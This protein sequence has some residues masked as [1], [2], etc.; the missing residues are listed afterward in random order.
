MKR[1]VA[2][3]GAI[4]SVLVLVIGMMTLNKQPADLDVDGQDDMLL[5]QLF[6]AESATLGADYYIYSYRELDEI[7]EA[8]TGI[9]QGERENVNALDGAYQASGET[10]KAGSGL[11]VTLK[12]GFGWL[13]T[14]MGLITI[15]A[16]VNAFSATIIFKKKQA[17]R[18][19]ERRR[20]RRDL[21]D[22]LGPTLA[23]PGLT[24]ST[25][26]D[27]IPTNPTK[28]TALVK[29]LQ[30]EIRATVGHIR[31]LVYDLRPQLSTN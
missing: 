21:H 14:A 16:L 19:E 5:E 24:A 7:V 15:A 11:H 31:R 3:I 12:N 26:A 22:H 23:S 13:M 8:L 4:L 27:L 10:I 2:L 1:A 25:A 17:A 9:Y 18:E 20:L 28:A 30:I 6:D 29:V